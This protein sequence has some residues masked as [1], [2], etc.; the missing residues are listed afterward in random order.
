MLFYWIIL[1]NNLPYVDLSFKNLFVSKRV[2]LEKN[3]IGYGCL[4]YLIV[5]FTPVLPSGA[6]FTDY[7]I[8]LFFLNLSVLYGCSKS[9]NIFNNEKKY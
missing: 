6:F 1:C 9:M 8:T 2:I 5:L 7:N 4:S 3:Y